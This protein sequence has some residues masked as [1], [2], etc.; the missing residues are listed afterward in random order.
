MPDRLPDLETVVNSIMV[1]FGTVNPRWLVVLAMAHVEQEVRAANN[2][3]PRTEE[4]AEIYVCSVFRQLPLDQLRILLQVDTWS[5]RL[6][7]CSPW[8]GLN[9]K[10]T[11]QHEPPLHEAGAADN[12]CLPCS[13]VQSALTYH[14]TKVGPGVD[15]QWTYFLASCL[16]SM[17]QT[18][19]I[20][21]LLR[22]FPLEILRRV[23]QVA[24]EGLDPSL[25]AHLRWVTV[26]GCRPYTQIDQCSATRGVPVGEGSITVQL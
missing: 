7:Q 12:S 15:F 6:W 1:D 9:R 5:N 20:K 19:D 3:P 10:T 21:S 25:S 8:H 2:V 26:K 23:L 14:R 22:E 16:Y 4:E 13:L 18:P 24:K 17:P 11:D